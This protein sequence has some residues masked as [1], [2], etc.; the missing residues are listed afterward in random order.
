MRSFVFISPPRCGTNSLRYSL[1]L[2]SKAFNHLSATTVKAHLGGSEWRRRFTFAL[3]R[4]PFSRLVS[5]YFYCRTPGKIKARHLP[6]YAGSFRHW[7]RTGC[8]THL[9]TPQF[10]GVKPLSL[11]SYLLDDDR[12]VMVDFVGRVE[13]YG[14]D[15]KTI[16]RGLGVKCPR[17]QHANT[18]RHRHYRSYYTPEMRERVEHMFGDDL[19]QFG[20]KF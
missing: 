10:R 6:L 12:R 14:Q 13:N 15:F 2:K 19:R 8:P 11:C 5:Y 3:I 7:L 1:G 9:V 18:S 20:Y 4:N 16:C 17:L